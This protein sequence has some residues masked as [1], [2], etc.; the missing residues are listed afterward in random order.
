MG[1]ENPN[2]YPHILIKNILYYV[3]SQGTYLLQVPDSMIYSI[4]DQCHSSFGG[5][6]GG[7][8]RTEK[9]LREK[10]VFPFLPKLVKEYCDQ[11]ISCK[12]VKGPKPPIAEINRWPLPLTPFSRV[13]VDSIGK[14]PTCSISGAK[15]IL[16]FRDTLTRYCELIACKTRTAKEFATALLE[17]I[18]CR[19]STP[20]VLVS[21]RAGEFMS[22]V[23]KELCKAWRIKTAN[24]SAYHPSSNALVERINAD[25]ENYLRHF[26]NENHRDWSKYLPFAQIAINSAFNRSLGTSPHFVLH[27]YV[28]RLPYDLPDYVSPFV[29]KTSEKRFVSDEIDTLVDRMEQIRDSVRDNLQEATCKAMEQQHKKAVVRDFKIGDYVFILAIKKPHQSSKL[30]KRYDGPYLVK[31]LMSK[32]KL[33]L[34]CL[35][36]TKTFP[37]HMDNVKLVPAEKIEDSSFS[38]QDGNWSSS[39]NKVDKGKKYSN[40][41]NDLDDSENCSPVVPT[42]QPTLSHNFNMPNTFLFPVSENLPGIPIPATSN[43]APKHSID[44]PLQNVGNLSHSTPIGAPQQFKRY[45]PSLSPIQQEDSQIESLPN[46]PLAT[47]LAQPI[48]EVSPIASPPPISP[49]PIFSPLKNNVMA[50]KNTISDV[51]SPLPR[52]DRRKDPSFRPHQHFAGPRE[53]SPRRLRS[54]TKRETI[55][56][57]EETY[58][59]VPPVQEPPVSLN[60]PTTRRGNKLY[61][62]PPTN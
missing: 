43:M 55:N 22:Q 48:A 27:G 23:F 28:R 31:N 8:L 26:T 51:S 57:P 7:Y 61:Y 38:F 58:E 44:S 20:E 13:H 18:I 1:K 53:G 36:S 24:V 3:N 35:D 17:R 39:L 40:N 62:L 12:L 50:P 56:P 34:A 37:V 33:L 52:D 42:F 9:R 10:Y 29:N 49:A 11:C 46:S 45:N 5:G 6:H 21:D 60:L 30:V 25:V 19:H 47:P 32:N 14:L 54:H 15:Y 41:T 4:I 2:I 59:N 16:V